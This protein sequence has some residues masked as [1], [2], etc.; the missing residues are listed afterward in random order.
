MYARFLIDAF[1]HALPINTDLLSHNIYSLKLMHS[2]FMNIDFHSTSNRCFL[3][4]VFIAVFPIYDACANVFFWFCQFT[5][6]SLFFTQFGVHCELVMLLLCYHSTCRTSIRR[7]P[8][9][10]L[11]TFLAVFFCYQY[12]LTV[13]VLRIHC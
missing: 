1:K 10:S 7:Q 5:N 13:T 8:L 4:L 11:C 9:S 2:F 3:I 6:F 12:W